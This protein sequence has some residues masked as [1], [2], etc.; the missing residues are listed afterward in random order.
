M[1]EVAFGVMLHLEGWIVRDEA[2]PI[3]TEVKLFV[4]APCKINEDVSIIY[5]SFASKMSERVAKRN[6]RSIDVPVCRLLMEIRVLWR[7]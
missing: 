6:Y 1:W 4:S 5:S 3:V 7:G 2:V